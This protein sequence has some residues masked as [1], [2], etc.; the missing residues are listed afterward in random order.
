MDT[1][2]MVELLRHMLID[3]ES[4][5]VLAVSRSTEEI[6]ESLFPS[7]DMVYDVQNTDVDA[8]ICTFLEAEIAERKL[9]GKPRRLKVNDPALEPVIVSRLQKGANGM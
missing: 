5:K 3:C 6:E 1:T 9:R 4:V 8:D 7:F 2:D